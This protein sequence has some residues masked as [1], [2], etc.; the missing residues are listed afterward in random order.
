MVLS[1]HDYV[2]GIEYK[3][4]VLEAIYHA[5]GRVYFENGTPRYEYTITDHLGNTR[6][7]FS[8]KDGDGVI[9]Q[10]D[11]PVTNEVLQENH[12]YPFG[13]AMDGQWI[14]D[15]GRESKYRFNGK[16][17]NE[18]FGLG[19]YDYGARWY[20]ASIGR[21]NAVDPKSDTFPSWSPYNYAFNNPT[22]FIDPDGMSPDDIILGE[23]NR[24]ALF[25][26]LQSLTNDR[27][28]LN[29]NTGEVFV[30]RANSANAGRNL[31][32]GTQLIRDLISDDN[33]T[34]IVKIDRGNGTE[35]V[36]SDGNRISSPQRGVEYDAKVSIDLSAPN[37]MNEDLTRGGVPPFITLGHE[38]K[39]ARDFTKGGFNYESFPTAYDFDTGKFIELPKR[40]FNSR[41]F[42]NK[43]RDEHGLKR[44]A[45]PNIIIR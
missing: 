18:D 14:G 13:M 6:L 42:E 4:E 3:N 28:T 1:T 7:T 17:L 16:E 34:S 27:L 12:Y 22:K 23:E 9:D 45:I 2:G 19:W 38:L 31:S 32:E 5:E 26:R 8:D 36:D 11:D 15:P 29:P 30:L 25:N 37:T 21:W 20:D 35:A 43:I 41:V 39:H 44:R 24:N 40:E 10:S 33:T